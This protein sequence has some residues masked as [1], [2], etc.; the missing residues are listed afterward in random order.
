MDPVPQFSYLVDQLSERFTYIYVV[1]AGA[2]GDDEISVSALRPVTVTSFV[3]L[4]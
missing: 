1:S 4:S 3:Q 2:M